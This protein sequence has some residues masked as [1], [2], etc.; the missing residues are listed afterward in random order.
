MDINLPDMDGIQAFKELQKYEETK[1][2]PVVAISAG[3]RDQ[4]IKNALDVGFKTYVIKPVELP[5]LMDTIHKTL[6]LPTK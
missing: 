3:A 6:G 4:D 5:L 1:S 2:I